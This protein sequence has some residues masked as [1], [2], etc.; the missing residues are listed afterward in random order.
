MWLNDGVGA[1]FDVAL[2]HASF[3]IK[4]G[5]SSG[6]EGPAFSHSHSLVDIHQFGSG[7]SPKNFEWVC[8]DDRYA[9]LF[10]FS[11]NG[12]HVRRVELA[13]RVVCIEPLEIL[14]K[15]RDSEGI[16]ARIDFFHLLLLC[17]G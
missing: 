16:K 12:S 7:V 8:A 14:L 5:D 9:P 11:Q 17:I 2:N 13:M 3:R 6:H 15:C 4:D 1:Y 10:R